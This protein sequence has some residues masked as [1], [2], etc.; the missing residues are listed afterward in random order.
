MLMLTDQQKSKTCRLFAEY[1]ELFDKL[2]IVDQNLAK[3]G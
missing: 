3:A 1:G 2:F